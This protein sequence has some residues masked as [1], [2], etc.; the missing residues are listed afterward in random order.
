LTVIVTIEAAVIALL[1]VLVAGLLRS[2]AEILRALHSLGAGIGD[3]GD[4]HQGGVGDVPI[5]LTDRGT[6]PRGE[7]TAVFDITGRSPGD[8]ALSIAVNSP[9]VDTL[10]AFLSGGCATCANFWKAFADEA[11][12]GLPVGTRLVVVTRGAGAESP[13]TVRRLAP[14]DVPV[15]MSDAAWEDYGVPGS[16]YFIYVN[17]AAG[18]V[19]GEGSAATWSEVVSFLR[20]ALD[21]A[22]ASKR[23][24]SLS[25]D[26]REARADRAL[27]AAGIL[28][29]DERLHPRA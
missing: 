14:P 29:G 2:H 22:A 9:R 21:D 20:E 27:L 6:S 3:T 23:G 28:P 4:H 1:A 18:R 15:V 12:L 19:S 24:L 13:G 25:G 26:D 11:A 7:S 10:L 5:S 16:P 17:G 8:E